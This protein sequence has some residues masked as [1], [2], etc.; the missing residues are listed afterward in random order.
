MQK[1]ILDTVVAATLLFGVSACGSDAGTS[2]ASS[3]SEPITVVAGSNAS[4]NM[5]ADWSA[6]LGPAE[7]TREQTGD[8]FQLGTQTHFSQGWDAA[9]L[10][11]TSQLGTHTIR[12]TVSWTSV[13]RIRGQYDFNSSAVAT[14]D[15]FCASGGKITLT[16]VPKN[17]LYDAGVSVY[18]VDGQAGYANY[19][20]ALAERFGSCL[21]ALEIGNEVN[22]GATLDYPAGYDH[23]TT[24]VSTLRTLY[25]R[26]KA[27]S[28]AVT[29]L[30]GSTNAI[31]TGFLETLFAVGMLSVIDGVAVHPYRNTPEG[32][33][34]EIAH[35]KDV[36]ARY[37]TPKPIWATEYSFGLSN[38]REQAAA[39]VKSAVQL[40]ASGVTH[41]NWY[42]LIEQ[43]TFPNMGLFVGQS[44]KLS[45]TAFR[46]MQDSILPYGAPVRI[47]TQGRPVNLFKIGTNRWVVWGGDTVVDFGSGATIRDVLGNQLVS[48]GRVVATAEP[49]IVEN[50]SSY[51]FEDGSVVA[52]SLY[53][54][55]SGDWSY[56]RRAK[57]GV[58]T[59]LGWFDNDFT[60]YFGDRWSKPLRIN[61]DSAATAGDAANPTRAVI[62]YKAPRTM[63][64]DVGVCLSKTVGGD[65]VDYLVEKNG[66]LITAGVLTNSAIL[67]G[68]KV[69]LNPNDRVDVS[70]GPNKIA[71]TDTLRYRI[72]IR[73]GGGSAAEICSSSTL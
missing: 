11:L 29:I 20:V 23:A 33:D 15:R 53:Q 65:G 72:I 30:G 43:K 22:G 8:G 12:D 61:N 16:I 48:D 50:A 27:V 25:P 9:L 18:S 71:G 13:E 59:A 39:L 10:D 36:M 67:T 60:S 7:A 21:S 52:D 31:G 44:P 17:A 1:K 35:L 66:V 68:M 2:T 41:A 28:P 46:M 49:V 40:Y 26:V 42:A 70:F 55:G 14:L 51:G 37:G 32:I 73:R 38:Q 69:D 56:Y 24:Y 64:V 57:T 5:P 6:V 63:S 34:I 54:F 58:E 47:D 3:T 19:L 4:T 62:R 45:A